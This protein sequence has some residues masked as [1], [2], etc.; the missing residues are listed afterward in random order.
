M[1]ADPA[2]L[3]ASV[4]VRLPCGCEF[5]QTEVALLTLW[6]CCRCGRDLDPAA[7]VTIVQDEAQ[8]TSIGK[9]K[10][11]DSLFSALVTCLLGAADERK[12]LLEG[13]AQLQT[14]LRELA[15]ENRH[16]RECGATDADAEQAANNKRILDAV[17]KLRRR[18]E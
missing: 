18:L 16:L 11:A 12:T 4:R 15:A 5:A 14:Q 9:D 17:A 2:P 1:L 6:K 10:F 7:P 13:A 3:A 8:S